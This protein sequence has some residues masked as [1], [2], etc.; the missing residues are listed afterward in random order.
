MISLPNGDFGGSS[1]SSREGTGMPPILLPSNYLSHPLQYPFLIF[2]CF[3]SDALRLNS[4]S[5]DALS[6][7]GL[8]LFLSGRLPQALQHATS[9]LRLDPGHE[10]AQRLRKRVK[11]VEKLKEEGNS[12]FKIGKLQDALTKYTECLDVRLCFWFP[13][14]FSFFAEV[15]TSV[16]ENQRKKGKGVRL[17]RPC[18]LIERRHCSRYVITFRS[19]FLHL[20]NPY[21][22]TDKK[23]L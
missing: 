1:W 7:R 21:S 5:P 2:F 9:A 3:Y 10:P 14:V 18:F 23:K 6:L 22:S 12:A 15:V 11:D 20:L 19:S 17:G 16:S 8:V 4:N 13:P